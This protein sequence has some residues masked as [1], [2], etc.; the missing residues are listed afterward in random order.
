MSR[1]ILVVDDD[2]DSLMI[3]RTILEGRSY[4]VVTATN[5]VDALM[6]LKSITPDVVL[7]DV[8]MPQMSGFEVLDRIKAT[9]AT[10]RTPVILLTAKVNDDDVM[11]GYQHGADYYITKPC[12]PK[13][14]IYGIDLVLGRTE[15]PDAPE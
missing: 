7:L 12:T 15:N 4:T 13:Q 8:M 11:S 5:G 1:T 14:L 3:L 2:P 9:H 10:S 6:A